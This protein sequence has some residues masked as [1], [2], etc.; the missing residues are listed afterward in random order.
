[1]Y[2]SED[3]LSIVCGDRVDGSEQSAWE[4]IRR[5]HD[6]VVDCDSIQKVHSFLFVFVHLRSHY[7]AKKT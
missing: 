5:V 2:C 3:R 6:V 1:V 7:Y 4:S